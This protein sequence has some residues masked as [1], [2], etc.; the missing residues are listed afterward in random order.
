MKPGSTADDVLVSWI[1]RLGRAV[2]LIGDHAVDPPSLNELAR[3]AAV[4]TVHLRRIWRG[5]L[6]ESLDETVTRLHAASARHRRTEAVA[7]SRSGPRRTPWHE[8]VRVVTRGPVRLVVLRHE[9]GGDA[10]LNRTFERLWCWSEREG[11]V[12]RLQGIYGIPLEDSGSVDADTA[13]YDAAFAMHAAP[14]SAPFRRLELPGGRHACL[15]HRG[16]HAS[17]LEATQRLVGDWLPR[18]GWQPGHAPVHHQFLR[19]GKD[20]DADE[21]LANIVLPLAEPDERSP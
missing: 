13:P 2:D 11:T 7:P 19:H 16:S 18:S 5:V 12:G 17:L 21:W 3:I 1:S 10:S 9:G 14:V 20:I 15:R 4:P 6:G 8:D